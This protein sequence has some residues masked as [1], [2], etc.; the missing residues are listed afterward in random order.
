[1]ADDTA[2]KLQPKI[3]NDEAGNQFMNG[4]V[5]YEHVMSE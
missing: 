1:V 4:L 5:Q 2:Q 3:E